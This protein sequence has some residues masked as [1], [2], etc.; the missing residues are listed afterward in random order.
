MFTSRAEDRLRLRQDNADQRLTHLGHACGLVGSS[1]WNQFQQ[2]LR[3]LEA[4]R[5][6]AL[7]S[8]VGGVA[9][10][11]LIKRPD[12]HTQDLPPE[13]RSVAQAHIWELVE[14]DMKYEGYAIRQNEHNRTLSRRGDDRIPEGFDFSR[15]AGL[16]AETRQKLAAIRPSTMGQASRIAGITPADISIIHIWL[17]KHT[18]TQSNKELIITNE[19][20]A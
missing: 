20:Q 4:V 3:A 16:R 14:T 10:A 9:L 19:G 18:L 8:N 7:K 15:V 13:I 6:A 2:K 17:H 1:R 11:Q 12:F 5:T